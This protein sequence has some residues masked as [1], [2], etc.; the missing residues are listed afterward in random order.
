MKDSGPALL[1]KFQKSV[2]QHCIEK[3]MQ[4]TPL[5]ANNVDQ[6]KLNNLQHSLLNILLIA[7]FF[8]F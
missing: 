5:I 3:L 4:L 7:I 2:D 6:L 1:H 8:S